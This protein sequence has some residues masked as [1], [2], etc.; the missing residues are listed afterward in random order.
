MNMS[1]IVGESNCALCIMCFPHFQAKVLLL[2]AA[3]TICTL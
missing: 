2:K 1:N 3:K